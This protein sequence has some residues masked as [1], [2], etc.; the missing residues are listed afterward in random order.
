MIFKSVKVLIATIGLGL[1]SAAIAEDLVYYATD[2]T[3]TDYYFDA[4][5]IRIPTVN[6]VEVWQIQDASKDKTVSYRTVKNKLRI[7]CSEETFGFLSIVTYRADG[8]VIR[9][10]DYKYPTMRS[11]VPGSTINTLFKT[12]C[13]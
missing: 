5:T 7:N 9:A 8:T 12:L 10:D 11:T 1:G 6:T 2:A 4:E 3:G 13:P